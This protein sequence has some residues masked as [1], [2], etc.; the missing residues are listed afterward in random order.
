MLGQTN[1]AKR[2]KIKPI[3]VAEVSFRKLVAAIGAPRGN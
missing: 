1:R 2:A 3:S